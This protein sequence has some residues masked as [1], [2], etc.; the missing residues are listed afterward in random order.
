M[1]NFVKF[2]VVSAALVAALLVSK[3]HNVKLI[4]EAQAA[5]MWICNLSSTDAGATNVCT[6]P[7][8]SPWSMHPSS[9]QYGQTID[10][11]CAIPACYKTD[12]VTGGVVGDGGINC[13]NDVPAWVYNGASTAN[14]N[15]T[16]ASGLGQLPRSR[17]VTGK[18]TGIWA[19]AVDA[20]N[21]NCSVSIVVGGQ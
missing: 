1:K 8:S 13:A 4:E 6:W 10:I 17:F 11:W 3:H 19:L 16:S 15:A 9:N 12:V 5:D 18:H 20:G 2:A 14:Q 21:P 7:Q